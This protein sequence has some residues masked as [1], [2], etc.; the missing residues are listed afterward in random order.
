MGKEESPSSW[1][2]RAAE[3]GAPGDALPPGPHGLCRR[4]RVT[5]DLR[6]WGEDPANQEAAWTASRGGVKVGRCS[7]AG[8]QGGKGRGYGREGVG[9]G[10]KGGKGR[11]YERRQRSAQGQKGATG[12]SECAEPRAEPHPERCAPAPGVHTQRGGGAARAP[13]GPGP[14]AQPHAAYRGDYGCGALLRRKHP[15]AARPLLQI[16]AAPQPRLAG[17]PLLTVS[18]RHLL[19]SVLAAA[20]AFAPHRGAARMV[21]ETASSAAC[22]VSSGGDRLLLR[23][24]LEAVLS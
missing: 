7:G 15:A 23:P 9:A 13:W 14:A 19:P 3:R 21:R 18:L 22:R 20:V 10:L 6:A 11:G 16:P 8:L 17:R 12:T 4:W 2:R 5:G 24:D 1:V